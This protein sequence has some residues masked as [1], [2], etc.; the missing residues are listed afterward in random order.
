MEFGPQARRDSQASMN[1]MLD[2]FLTHLDLVVFL[3][4]VFA[5]VID[6]VA[7]V[8]VLVIVLVVGEWISHDKGRCFLVL[9]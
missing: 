2:R 9:F 4:D 1:G 8:L 5:V 7:V 3:I 6:V